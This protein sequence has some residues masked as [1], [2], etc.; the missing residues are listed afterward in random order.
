MNGTSQLR[1]SI[2]RFSLR[3]LLLLMFAAA[4][5]I[6]WGT[7]LYRSQQLSPTRF[8]TDNE[9]WQQDVI[10]VYQ[11]LGEPPFTSNAGSIMHS[12]GTS[13]VQRTIV[14]RIPL[15]LEKQRA[16]LMAFQKRVREKLSKAGCTLAGESSGS[17]ANDVVVIGYQR[18]PVAGSFQICVGEAGD[19][20]VGVVVTMQE[21]RGGI[22]GFGLQNS[23]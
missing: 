11:E 12:E 5:L 15:S 20:R 9:S 8:F 2:W 19:N 7:L 16:F 23:E 4:A 10:A 21:E 3:E 6:G 14:Y 18:G 22:Q 1:R 17:G 13:A